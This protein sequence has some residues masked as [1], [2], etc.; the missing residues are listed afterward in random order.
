MLLPLL[1]GA[2]EKAVYRITYDC[3]ALYSRTRD[4]YRWNLDIGS[5]TAVFYSPNWR[6]Q[7]ILQLHLSGSRL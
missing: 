1:L 5:T 6:G 7:T 4:V 3:D 2:Q